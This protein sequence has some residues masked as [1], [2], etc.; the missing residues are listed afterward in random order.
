M[1][2][3]DVISRATVLSVSFYDPKFSHLQNRSVRLFKEL[4]L[5]CIAP[6]NLH[7]PPSFPLEYAA[8]DG[9]RSVLSSLNP[10]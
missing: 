3:A 9:F 7:E 6:S 5:L 4:F 2:Q 10:I 1:T 8:K